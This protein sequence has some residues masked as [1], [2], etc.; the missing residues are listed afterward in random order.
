[1]KKSLYL[2]QE[3]SIASNV[4][5]AL[6]SDHGVRLIDFRAVFTAGD[7]KVAAFA[8]EQK[9]TNATVAPEP[10]ARAWLDAHKGGGAILD[11]SDPVPG[12]T[13]VVRKSLNPALKEQ[14]AVWFATTQLSAANLTKPTPAAYKYVTGLSHYTPD[15]WPGL[16]KVTAAEVVELHKAGVAVI[17]VRTPA[18]YS[19]KHIESAQLVPYDE[20]S[21]RIAGGDFSRDGF[22]IS[23]LSEL[24]KIVVYCNGPECWKSFKAALRANASK[25]F[26]AIYW[27]RGGLPEWERS[28]LPISRAVAQVAK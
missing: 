22:D 17:D 26:E 20:Q 18:E 1:M 19:A 15:D 6:L 4:G 5:T 27:F 11:M 14:L 7:Y 23:K 28:G 12:Q 16:R 2:P 10:I 21:P 3:D 25:S 9:I 8:I 24:K 13:L